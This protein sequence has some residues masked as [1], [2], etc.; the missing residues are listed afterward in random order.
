MSQDYAK[1]YPSRISSGTH[2]AAVV[3]SDTDDLLPPPR[4]LYVG[5]GGD[6]AIRDAAGNVAVRK[7][8]A[9]GSE[10]SFE[11]ARVMATGTTASDI[12]AIW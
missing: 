8:V 9:A 6:L 10:I 4:S 5:T 1:S 2:H 12:L 3:P 7:N 11:A